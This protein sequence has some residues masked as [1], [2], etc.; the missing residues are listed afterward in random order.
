MDKPK[1]QTEAQKIDEAIKLIIEANKTGLLTPEQ[2]SL[3]MDEFE[4][5]CF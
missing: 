4:E 3:L 5:V 2:T 1:E